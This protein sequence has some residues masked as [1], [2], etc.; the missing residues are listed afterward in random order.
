MTP[1]HHAPPRAA[2]ADGTVPRSGRPS[3]SLGATGTVDLPTPCEEVTTRVQHEQRTT[4]APGLGLL[5]AAHLGP[6][7]A[8]TAVAGLLAASSDDVPAGR[9]ALLVGAVLTGQLSIG[10]SNDLLDVERD[11]QVHRT[12]KP[13]ATGEVRPGVVRAA[14]GAALAAT[15]P[16]SLACGPAAGLTH[17]GCV[18][19]GGWAYNTRLK[20]SVWSWL[21]YAVAFGALPVVA[22]LAG[23]PGEVPEAW[24]P[25]SGALLGVGAHL[26]NALPD[27]DDDAATGVRG[28]PHRIGARRLAPVAT[29]VLVGASLVVLQ[30]L[31]STHP[32]AALLGL[33]VVA[34]LAGVALTSTGRTP[35]RAAV[36]IALVDVALMAGAR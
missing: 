13:L 8:V 16:L 19:G 18:V 36:A 33:G 35:F 3:S 14:C 27:L 6:A 21:P 15:V 31:R 5:R 23:S 24:V 26:V 34:G 2:T 9:G 11:R 32:S 7:L 12:D 22:S 10:W 17:L 20:S 28:L 25:L 30:Q 1:F 29:G 4:P